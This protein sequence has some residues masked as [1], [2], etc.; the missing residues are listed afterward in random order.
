MRINR[1]HFVAF[2]PCGTTAAVLRR[3]AAGF[4]LPVTVHD[5][6]L[7]A[8]RETVL[9]F[10]PDDLV[11][12][13]F[14]VYGGRLPR[15]AGDIFAVLRGADTPALLV[16]AYGN[17]DYEDA[18][19]ETQHKAE[20][21]GFVPIAAA[22]AV[23]EHCMAPRVAAGRPDAED[24]AI[25][26]RFGT[27][28]ETY[29]ATLPSPSAAHFTAPGEFP[30]RKEINQTKGAPRAA[31]GCTRCGAC[32]KVCPTGAIRAETPEEADDEACIRC[33]ACIKACP[34]SARKSTLPGFEQ[35]VSWLQDN[36]AER[37]EPEFFP[38]AVQ[39]R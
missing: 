38:E 20:T 17:R 13:A 30:Y 14:P 22:A 18:L 27:A 10:G 37:R 7:P 31:E 2:S 3:I 12:I 24:A 11:C 16:A 5:L 39:P 4:S 26:A 36:C 25:L 8:A 6:T 9:A 1:A 23:A 34:E 19:L 32:V 35:I 29:A 28:V 15:N 21:R 33:M